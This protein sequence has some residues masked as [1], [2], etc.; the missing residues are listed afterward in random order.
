MT[1]TAKALDCEGCKH[2]LT[3]NLRAGH[4]CCGKHEWPD[5]EEGPEKGTGV[6]VPYKC[7]DHTT[8]GGIK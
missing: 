8:T 4:P 5:I 1:K 2:V 3:V 6:Y 7:N